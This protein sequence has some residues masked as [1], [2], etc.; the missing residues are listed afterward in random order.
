MNN[1]TQEDLQNA[2]A[3]VVFDATEA[4]LLPPVETEDGFQIVK[5]KKIKP[6]KTQ[7]LRE[8]RTQVIDDLKQQKISEDIANLTQEI[9][10][11]V[12]G[13]S[14]LE[15]IARTHKLAIVNS[16]FF[17]RLDSTQNTQVSKEMI[18]AA[19]D[20]EIGEDGPVIENGPAV[21]GTPNTLFLL[22]VDEVKESHIPEMGAVTHSIKEKIILEKALQEAKGMA[23]EFVKLH[24]NAA[25]T[26]V[27]K[28]ASIR[29]KSYSWITMQ[30]AT[31][32]KLDPAII[33]KAFAQP[34]GGKDIISINDHIYIVENLDIRPVEVES[35]LGEYKEMK[36]TLMEV[37][38]QDIFAQ[39]MKAL[40]EKHGVEV[41]DEEI[42]TLL[43]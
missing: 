10:D 36:N 9:E 3:D 28:N 17:E 29:S 13:G 41:Y 20:Q 26:Y 30:A 12:S 4:S 1:I 6:S 37:L 16:G 7:T 25:D 23:E 27:K 31:D 11:A 39:Y 42:N 14:T 8:V 18:K 22:R 5:I 24:G 19:F 34:K 40:K 38:N 33:E 21:E 35:N 15:E 43:N 32:K 2:V